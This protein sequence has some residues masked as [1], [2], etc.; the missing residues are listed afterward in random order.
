MT[1]PRTMTI[2]Q[3]IGMNLRR[4][5][6]DGGWTQDRVASACRWV[7]LRGSGSRIAQ[8]ESGDVAP[9]LPNLLRL[10]A[11]L[12]SLGDT[13]IGLHDLLWWEGP[14]QV[15][16]DPAETIAGS[17][18]LALLAGDDAGRIHDRLRPVARA[19]DDPAPVPALTLG[20]LAG[21]GRADERVARQLGLGKQQMQELTQ[22][23]W[24]RGL[25]EERD[26]RVAE[27]THKH[28]RQVTRG[29]VTVELREELRAELDRRR[30]SVPE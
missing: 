4:I 12:D 8:I 17:D 24:G 30:G 6:L 13:P 19:E 25:E 26:R 16:D 5:R 18:L 14:I 21:F 9:T 28:S 27:S 11:A 1:T 7:G 2:P 10:A 23:L 20:M 15:A 22:S 3:V 29:M